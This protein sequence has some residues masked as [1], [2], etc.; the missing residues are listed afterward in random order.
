MKAADLSPMLIKNI[1]KVIKGKTE[2]VRL[3]ICALF[4]G[5]NVL[6]EDVPGTGKT[7]LARAL[8]ASVGSEF[9]RIQF[10]PDLLPGDLTGITYFNPKTS[11]FVFRKGAVFT[12]ILLADEINRATPRT[13]SALLEAMAERQVTVDGETYA[14]K[15]P[16]FVIATQNPVETQGTYPLPEAQLDRFAM[17][18]SLGYPTAEDYID[19]IT[20]NSAGNAIEELTPVCMA[21]DITEVQKECEKV[22]IHP[23]LIRYIATLAEKSRSSEGVLLGL[24][25]RG[26]LSVVQLSRACAAAEGRSFVTPEDVKTVFPHA[27]V[28]RLILSGGYR[29]REGYGMNIIKELLASVEVPTEDW[30]AGGI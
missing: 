17:R 20:A 2:T 16:F 4:S 26:I 19:I 8:A 6:M 27:A 22:Y 18:L 29:H 11:E 1:E 14:L 21:E 5:G 24:S 10:T 7:M 3:V 28:H 30:T 15:P 9:K 25:T 23:D 13:Q 12:N